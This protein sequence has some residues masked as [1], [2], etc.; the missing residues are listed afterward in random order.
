[1][2]LAILENGQREDGS[3]DLPRPLHAFFGT[4]RIQ[5]A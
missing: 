1:M 3:V 2:I 5:L 4:D